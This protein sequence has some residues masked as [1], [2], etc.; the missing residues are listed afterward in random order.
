MTGMGRSLTLVAHRGDPAHA[1]ENTLVSFR[2]AIAKGAKAVELDLR[3]TAD[4]VWVVLHDPTF[5]RTTGEKGRL[6]QTP[7]RAVKLLDA[8][9]WF[10]K[11]FRAERIPRVEEAL[12]LCRQKRVK[13]F[14]DVKVSGGEKALV[15][16][17][18]RSGWMKQ[19]IVGLGG[20]ASLRHWRRLLPHQPLFWVTGFRAQVTPQRIVAG[21]RAGITGLAAYKRWVSK[22]AIRQ[23]HEAGLKLYVWTIRTPRQLKV[24]ARRD[25]DGIM[26]EV[27]PSPLT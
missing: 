6:A 27:W 23:V 22:K 4:G 10:A 19:V 25:V 8:G 3:R 16:I 2:E 20:T 26:S 17:L 15:Q 1:P 12:R 18:K 9:E 21:R 7:W 24:F 14:F 5:T 11:R 13:L